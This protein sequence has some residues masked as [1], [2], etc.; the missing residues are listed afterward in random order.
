MH[1]GRGDQ[2][3]HGAVA[4]GAR[5][6]ARRPRQFPSMVSSIIAGASAVQ[7]HCN[8]L[9]MHHRRIA[10]PL[11]CIIGACIIGACISVYR[12]ISGTGA[13]GMPC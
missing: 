2:W 9:L 5:P 11:Q 8:A 7:V 10:N 4:S 13:A 1:A 12:S 6:L 3:R